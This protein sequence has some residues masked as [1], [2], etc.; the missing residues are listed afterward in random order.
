[1]RDLFPGYYQP[2]EE[3]FAELWEKC[4]F[5]FDTNVLLHIYRYSPK[6]RERLFD[7]L[8]KF[9]ERIWIPH[10]VAYEIHKNRLTVISDQ[11]GAYKEIQTILDKNL[12]IGALKDPLFKNFK[13]H[14]FIDVNKIIEDIEL[15]IKKIEDDL[16][17]KKQ[18]HPNY[19]ES[20]DL[21]DKLI[22]IINGKIGQ[23]Y[24]KDKLKEIHKDAEQRFKDSVP[25]GYEDAKEKPAPDKYGDVVIWRQL[26][27]YAKSEK[28]S[29]IFVTDDNKQD[30]WL[31]HDRKTVSPRPELVEEMRTE[32]GVRFYMY[33]ADR[34]LDYAQKF[35]NLS[36]QP[37]VIE[38]AREIRGQDLESKPL[39]T[40]QNLSTKEELKKELQIVK[41]D[42]A[43]L[44]IK[45]KKLQFPFHKSIFGKM[46]EYD[47][48]EKLINLQR[49]QRLAEEKLAALE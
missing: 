32:A 8:Q 3:E 30:W 11:S 25:P 14:P 1:M 41:E 7:I 4:I 29:L 22:A 35:L 46:E 37:E 28:K 42:Q 24:I 13:R 34:F 38:E 17:V 19:L 33:S 2:T 26:I 21:W 47:I 31:K 12:A 16:Q 23:P 39:L 9:Q 45:L 49:A 40:E 36:E 20:D 5:S 44:Q 15:V 43:L 27:D 18:A 6:T 10:Q 48:E